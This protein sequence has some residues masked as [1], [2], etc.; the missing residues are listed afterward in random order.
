MLVIFRQ[1]PM[2]QSQRRMGRIVACFEN[3]N[4]L[5]IPPVGKAIGTRHGNVLTISNVT[6]ARGARNGLTIMDNDLAFAKGA[7]VATTRKVVPA[8]LTNN[9]QRVGVFSHLPQLLRR[10]GVD[11]AQGTSRR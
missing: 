11:P 6:I 8:K 3:V 2:P 4:Q 7:L 5:R 10:F 9:L 1:L